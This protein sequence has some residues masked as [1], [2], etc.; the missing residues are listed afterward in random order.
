[1]KAQEKKFLLLSV[2][3]L[4]LLGQP[5]FARGGGLG[6]GFGGGFGAGHGY[7]GLGVHGFTGG[8]P[9]QD[10]EYGSSGKSAERSHGGEPS[11]TPPAVSQKTNA[12]S[13]S[14]FT[15]TQAK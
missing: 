3:V 7:G 6:G 1:M 9:H 15:P 13:A 11:V 14:T 5:A 2:A 4:I 10:G 8:F 12:D